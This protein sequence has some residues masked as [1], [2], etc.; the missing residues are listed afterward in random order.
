MMTTD[1]AASWQSTRRSHDDPDVSPEGGWSSS[2]WVSPSHRLQAVVNDGHGLLRLRK[3]LPKGITYVIPWRVT[4][5]YQQIEH[6]ICFD[7][8]ITYS[9]V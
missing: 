7:I 2:A 4:P 9:I 5:K 8:D 1:R 6:T 3:L